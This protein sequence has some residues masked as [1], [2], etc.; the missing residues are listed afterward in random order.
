MIEFRSKDLYADLYENPGKPLIVIIGGSRGG[1][2]SRISPDFL[3]Y[4][5]D[6]YSV[7]IFAYFGVD[8]LPKKLIKVP[9]EYF[10]EG[11]KSVEQKLTIGM[12]KTII[13]GNSK[14]AEAAL[15][16]SQYLNVHAI[17]ACVPSCYVWQGLTRGILDFL[18]PRSSWTYQGKQLPFIR[19]KFDK[20]IIKDIKKGIYLSCYEK[21]IKK[22]RKKNNTIDVTKYSGKLFLLSSDLDIFWPSKEMCDSIVATKIKQVNHK[23]LHVSGHYFQDTPESVSETISI[24]ESLRI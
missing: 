2:W 17:V 5:K 4:L 14:G 6:R 22:N 11:I 18:F 20:Q 12:D 1:I 9:I 15:L 3:K 21:S 13:I 16:V 23:V 24:L 7:L 8:R 19:M 10:V